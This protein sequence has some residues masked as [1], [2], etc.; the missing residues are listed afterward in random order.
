MS[1]V[2]IKG[3]V[4][5]LLPDSQVPIPILSKI[6]ELAE[7]YNLRVYLSTLQNIRLLDVKEENLEDIK[8]QLIAV[9]ANLKAPGKFLP[10]KVCIGSTYCRVGKVDTLSLAEKI[11][12]LFK[13]RT[14]MKPK[15]K[16]AVSG[17]IFCCSNALLEDIGIVATKKGFD[18]YAGGK[19]GTKPMAGR[20]IMTNVDED[21]VLETVET[22]VDFHDKK[23]PKKQRL[24]KLLDDPEFPF[25]EV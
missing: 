6:N 5:A 14:N 15:L 4:T 2:S 9:G 16:V 18:I 17:C 8:S 23:T 7:K 11:S 3:S 19:G 13:D 12:D 10:P 22:L 21:K 24:R 1:D 20:R 25:P